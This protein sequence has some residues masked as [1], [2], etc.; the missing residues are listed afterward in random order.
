MSSACHSPVRTVTLTRNVLL[1]MQK[2][3]A[4]LCISHGNNFQTRLSNLTL[5]SRNAKHLKL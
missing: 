2:L 1:N 3:P 5:L 4:I